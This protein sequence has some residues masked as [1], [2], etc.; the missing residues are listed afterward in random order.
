MSGQRCRAS[1]C[2]DGRHLLYSVTFVLLLC[3]KIMPDMY[4]VRSTLALSS[5][6]ASVKKQG[7]PPA[8]ETNDPNG[9]P[10]FPVGGFKGISNSDHS[11][12]DTYY[13]LLSVIDSMRVIQ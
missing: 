3:N 10:G 1:D 11:D 12:V 13:H 6:V 9:G 5:Y 2:S 8:V 7:N 4:C